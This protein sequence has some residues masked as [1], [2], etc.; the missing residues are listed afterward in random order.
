VPEAVVRRSLSALACSALLLLGAAVPSGASGPGS[1]G[2]DGIPRLTDDLGR[3]VTLRGWN[4]EDKA[5]RGDEALS[6]I[7]ERHFRDLR[8]HGF[9]FA[10]LLIFWDDIEPRPGEYD[11][12]YLRKID[13]ILDWAHRYDVQVL[14]DG[15]QDVCGP[16][17]GSRGLPEWA[18][19]TDAV[20]PASRRLVRRLLRTGGAA[21]VHP[22]LRGRRHP[23]RADPAVGHA[24]R[25][26]RPASRAARLRPAERTDG[27]TPRR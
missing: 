25:A 23:G 12:S 19:R 8:A 5:R 15:H 1:T 4:V 18:T 13:R 9:G 26:L 27:R 2:P 16:A 11:E 7:T 20:H 22:S 14:L 21:R 6:A 24:G 3:V 17:F 10:R